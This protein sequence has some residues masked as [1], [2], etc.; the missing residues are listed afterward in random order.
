MQ[1]KELAAFDKYVY[2]NKE[3]STSY[4]EL[5]MSVFILV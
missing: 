3:I 4:T 5:S 1:L 2:V